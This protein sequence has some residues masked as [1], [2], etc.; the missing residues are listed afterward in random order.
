MVA[1]FMVLMSCKQ[2]GSNTTSTTDSTKTTNGIK[3]PDIG[4]LNPGNNT[5]NNNTN[6]Q[7]TG[8]WSKS[9][10][11]KIVGDCIAEASKNISASQAYTYCNCM[12]D[13][14]EAKYPNEND[15]DTKLTESEM[16]AMKND[17]M[18]TQSN[19]PNNN[20]NQSNQ[21]NTYNNNQNNQGSWSSDEQN[22]FLRDCISTASNS[23]GNARATSY[24]NCMM[25]KI[26]KEY[27]IYSQAQNIPNDLINSWAKDCLR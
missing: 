18:G 3:L 26:M 8:T 15:A 17:C 25:Q 2:K 24:C 13:K 7:S 16:Q 14:V 10:K 23:I 5:N 1:A 27:P 11:D 4:K 9:Y 19:N 22:Q 6:T 21:N 12:A 20:Q